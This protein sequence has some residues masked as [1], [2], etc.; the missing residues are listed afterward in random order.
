MTDLPADFHL[1]AAAL[2]QDAADVA[3]YAAA[4]TVTLADALPAGCVTV[5]RARTVADKVRGRQ[6]EVR[7]VVVRL[8]EHALSLSAQHG[9]PVAEVHHEVRGVVL[10]RERVA[11]D[12]W[13]DTLA[14]ELVTYAAANARAAAALRRLVAGG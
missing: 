1:V 13:L 12:S 7:R 2:R 8:G 6:G 5:E 14:R 10:S 11:L 9:Q 3:A 4:L